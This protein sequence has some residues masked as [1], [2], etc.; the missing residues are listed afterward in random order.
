MRKCP[1]Q[2]DKIESSFCYSLIKKD[3]KKG[4]QIIWDQDSVQD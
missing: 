3:T 4:G 1:L 2:M